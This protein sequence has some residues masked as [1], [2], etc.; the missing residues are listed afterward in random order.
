MSRT[1][2]HISEAAHLRVR[3]DHILLRLNLSADIKQLEAELEWAMHARE[4]VLWLLDRDAIWPSEHER[5]DALSEDERNAARAELFS[6]MAAEHL[7]A[8][9]TDSEQATRAANS[10]LSQRNRSE[11]RGQDGR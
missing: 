11:S 3:A 2:R 9:A 8:A 10:A 5:A 4:M 7:H 1:C 6:R